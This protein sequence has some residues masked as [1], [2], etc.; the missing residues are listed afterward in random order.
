MFSPNYLKGII[1]FVLFSWMVVGPC[2]VNSASPQAGSVIKSDSLALVALYETSKGETWTYRTNWLTSTV[3]KWHGIKVVNNRV[4][5][6]VL[7]DNNLSGTLPAELGLL[8]QLTLLN[9]RS[10]RLTGQLPPELGLLAN[11]EYLYLYGNTLTGEIP[12]ELGNLANLKRLYLY[13][14]QLSGAIPSELGKLTQLEYLYLQSNRL[15]GNLPPELGQLKQ[16]LVL[17]L[18]SNQLEGEL[19]P[20]I[21]Q[22]SNLRNLYLHYNNLS[23]SIPTELGQLDLLTH[24][25]LHY[26]KFSGAI[27]HE[28]GDM[29]NLLYLYLNNNRL[30]GKLPWEIGQLTKLRY[31]YCEMN[32]LSDTIPSSIGNMSGLQILDMRINQLSG[33]LP[34]EIGLLKNLRQIDLSINQLS[35]TLPDAI[36][37]LSN[38]T[39][40]IIDRNQLSGTIPKVLN[41]LKKLDVLSL[42]SNKF[43]AF[44]ADSL[45]FNPALNSISIYDNELT[46]ED[47]EDK[48]E[49]QNKY[50]Y[51]SP[52]ANIGQRMV[53]QLDTGVNYTLDIECGG[54]QNRYEWFFGEESLGDPASES[55]YQLRDIRGRDLGAYHCKISNELVPDLVIASE[56]IILQLKPA[57]FQPPTDITLSN[58]AIDEGMPVGTEIGRFSTEDPDLD[59]WHFY[60]LAAGEGGE[61]NVHFFIAGNQLHSNEIFDYE[62]K[63]VYHIRVRTEDSVGETFTKSFTIMVENVGEDPPTA[64]LLSDSLINENMPVGSIVGTLYTESSLPNNS[65]TY[66]LTEGEG[67]EDNG[68]FFI[69]GDQLLSNERFDYE[70]RWQYQIRLKSTDREENFIETSFTIYIRDVDDSSINMQLL[71]DRLVENGQVGDL[72]GEFSVEGEDESMVYQF[73][74]ADDP[75]YPDNANFFIANSYLHAYAVFDYEQQAVYEIKVEAVN[76]YQSA[77]SELFTVYVDDVE[78]GA[79]P[80]D[81]FVPNAF[82]PNQDGKNDYFEIIG[83]EVYPDARLNVYNRSGQLVFSRNEYGNPGNGI[84]PLWWDGRFEIN[85]I[86]GEALPEA[87][88][89]M[90]LELRADTLV[91]QTILLKR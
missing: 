56:S 65:F 45:N 14:N 68:S 23:G 10:N 44:L 20:E 47:L 85:G 34:E 72:I 41:Q 9:L 51:Y 69:I 30:S 46:F 31:L 39:S 32:Q 16:L 89:F 55:S 6:I 5:E 61:D 88:Y 81:L 11:L 70:N 62:S 74:L 2:R 80:L 87:A 64:L 77:F 15:S 66:Q 19:P 40:L 83:I 17:Y 60:T 71:G 21:G 22:M 49:L 4:T 33:V 84:D 57:A 50:F 67:S 26:N 53:V 13:S 1:G 58:Q 38:L 90:V 43:T 37:Q 54:T 86:P 18:S 12:A 75:A 24:L 42:S 27:P 52:Q 59:D 63:S 48:M 79:G 3:D 36:G 8:D 91:K 82:S 25:Y 28:L 35:G 73:S 78:E 76:Q 7:Y 29:D